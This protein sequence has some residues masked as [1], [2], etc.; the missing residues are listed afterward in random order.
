MDEHPELIPEYIQRLRDEN[1]NARTAR[2]ALEKA[3]AENALLAPKA[4]YYDSFVGI[5]SLTNIRYTAKELCIPQ[6]KFIGYLLEKGYLFRDHHRKDRLFARAGERN[7]PLFQTKD[8]YLPDGT[9]SEYTLVTPDGKAHFLKRR[10]KILAWVPRES[11]E[12]E[13][14]TDQ[15]VYADDPVKPEEPR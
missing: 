5:D 12:G 9:K 2:E 3:Q 8:F 13:E 10:E 11:E 15:A 14:I 4:T 7:N 6:K 1:A